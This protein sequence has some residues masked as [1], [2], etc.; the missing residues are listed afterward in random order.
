VAPEDV[1]EDIVEA[2]RAVYRKEIEDKPENIQDQIIEGKLGKFYEQVCLL[3]QP[4]V[5]DDKRKVEEIITD[6]IGKIGENIMV[7]RFVRMEVG[8]D[9]E[10]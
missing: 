10:E 1:P 8:G 6:A 5:R 7:K 3:K 9:E 2:E 4:Y